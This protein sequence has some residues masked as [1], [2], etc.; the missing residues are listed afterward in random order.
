MLLFE[1]IPL[2]SLFLLFIFLLHNVFF[3]VFIVMLYNLVS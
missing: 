2:Y 3:K 1:I